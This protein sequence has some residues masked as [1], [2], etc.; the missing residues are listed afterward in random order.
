MALSNNT[1]E[2]NYKL[3]PK[4]QDKTV[5]DDD[6]IANNYTR[7]LIHL[8]LT[9]NWDNVHS[10][11]NIIIKQNN[12]CIGRVLCISKIWRILGHVQSNMLRKLLAFCNEH[13]VWETKDEQL[14]LYLIHEFVECGTVGHLKVLQETG[15]YKEDLKLD[16]NTA[17]LTLLKLEPMVPDLTDK[18][19]YLLDTFKYDTQ[20]LNNAY[21]I[22]INRFTN[23]PNVSRMIGQHL[24]K[25]YNDQ[26][27]VTQQSQ[28]ILRK[29]DIRDVV[30]TGVVSGP[31][32][33]HVIVKERNLTMITEDF[34]GKLFYW[35][36]HEYDKICVIQ[37]KT[38]GIISRWS[39]VGIECLMLTGPQFAS[40][41]TV[42]RDSDG[43]YKYWKLRE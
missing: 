39:S 6:H 24:F 35:K 25:I 4:H 37:V 22:S 42:T 38:I 31:G 1:I 21:I 27:P 5:F 43:N 12:N 9:D 18:L 34:D 36:V 10:M 23:V 19:K 32:E 29:H 17:L 28:Y 7:T 11:L 33:V 15:D 8:V 30:K 14:E 40:Q 16:G 13:N 20:D 2:I 26:E 3:I 41:F